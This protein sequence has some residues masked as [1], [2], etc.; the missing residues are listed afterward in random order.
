M[1][2]YFFGAPGVTDNHVLQCEGDA[3]QEL[4]RWDGSPSFR[5]GF[6]WGEG[7]T[8]KSL[9]LASALIWAS[10]KDPLLARHAAEDFVLDI[11]ADLTPAWC[12]DEDSICVWLEAYV[13]THRSP[14]LQTGLPRRNGR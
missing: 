10:C 3:R 2:R 1:L 11:V 13:L 5:V 8:S 9:A 7:L 14:Q 4:P 6:A 12:L